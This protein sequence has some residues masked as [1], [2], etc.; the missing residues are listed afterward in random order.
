MRSLDWRFL[1]AAG[2]LL[3]GMDQAGSA[4][5][6]PLV[7]FDF[8]RNLT[9]SGA[10]GGQG[11][12]QV[13]APGEGAGYDEGAFGSALDLTSASR[14][15][16]TGTQEPPSGS[17]VIFRH[18]ALDRLDS[19]TIALWFRQSPLAEGPSARLLSKVG[20]WDL[21]PAGA[22]VSL[23]LGPHP[24]KVS[25]PLNDHTAPKPA[26]RWHFVAVVVSSGSIR[27]Y[28]GGLDRPLAL[29]AE[30]P[31]TE[32][33]AAAPGELVLGN[34]GGI[35]PFNGWLDRIRIFGECLSEESIR[36]LFKEDLAAAKPPVPKTIFEL[37]RPEAGTHRFHLKRSD[38]PFSV[39]WQSRA[40]APA[41]MESFHTT[42]CLW[43]YGSDASVIRKIKGMGIGYQGT[44][45]GL[46]GQECSTVE[47]N[48]A[49]DRSG[50]HEDL[51]GN[52]NTPSW[53]A[54]FGPK[55]FTGCCNHPAFRQLF[56]EA[57]KRH[58]D[59]GVD[60][61]HVDDWTMNASW[62][63]SGAACFCEPCRSGFREWLR[64]R[65]SPEELR[66]LGI[67]DIR[68]FDYREHLKRTGVPDAAAYKAKIRDLPLTPQFTA[69]QVES[70]RAFFR[71]F[72]KRLDEWSPQKF[73]PVSVNGLLI[74]L[75]PNYN[76]CGIDVIDFLTGESS[77]SEDNQTE[78]DF[79]LAA[80]AAEA[81][82]I[83]QV[84]SPIPR[85][86]ARTRAAVA[87]TYALGQLHLVPWDIYMG[88][89]ASG[90]QPR[91]FGTREQ[92]GD[93]YDFI[94]EHPALFDDYEPVAE[95]GVLANADQA[96]ASL[97]AYCK[98]LASRQIPFQLVLG[99]NRHARL[100]IRPADLQRLRL[101]VELSPI[102]SFGG[103]D[104]KTIQAAR[105]SGLI[106]FVKPTA[107]LT[108]IAKLRSLNLLRLEA[109]DN[110]YAFPRVNGKTHS[111]AIHLVNWNLAAS[112]ERAECY[113]NIT[114]TMLQP[115]R[116]GAF[117]SAV[118]L[119]PGL[120]PVPL[121]PERHADSVRLTLPQLETWGVVKLD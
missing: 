95:V 69:F 10:L 110:V 68:S 77:Q 18:E 112:T 98:Q 104:Q 60:M 49:A 114:L 59:A 79:V 86:T 4:P 120:A 58:I 14:H 61:L 17:A 41:M 82:G 27:A 55:T 109:P 43:V 103:E 117:K 85:S 53:M 70:M 57:A 87:T 72:R 91:Y 90:I 8:E 80:K 113:R 99:A 15:G 6:S 119:Q 42:Q 19:F 121:T 21:M 9:N 31:R 116:W 76:V 93:L 105:E 51:D 20:S 22:G 94:H 40:E 37:A 29:C 50:R 5:A 12:V 33:L 23:I 63:L 25:Y 44:L 107:D 32:H 118:W 64:Q 115:P 1:F 96:D 52:K 74:N 45:N 111:A 30:Q 46:Q 26:G 11:S 101:L 48:A 106:R 47:R 66:K 83:T 28:S 13:Y 62:V 71:D 89:D 67:E 65:C 36:D 39:R 38:I 3:A 7:C 108:A 35:R 73:I 34:L 100:P 75:H 84:V 81:F 92:Y 54:A 56:F 88:S 102:E 78:A 16:G 97:A 24:T 2:V